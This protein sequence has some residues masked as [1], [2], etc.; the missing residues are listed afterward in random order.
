M[1]STTKKKAQVNMRVD[2][3][4]LA[5]A[6]E[7]I[8]SE[9]MDMTSFFIAVLKDVEARKQVPTELLPDKKT[10]RERLIDELYAEIQKGVDDFEEGKGKPMDEV[11]AK[12][13][14]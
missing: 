3:A 10:R 12:Y 1:T 2:A 13:E 9:N 6:K 7:I 8:N 5:H 4:L 14:L 11:F